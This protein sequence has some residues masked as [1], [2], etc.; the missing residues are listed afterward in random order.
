[1]KIISIIGARPQFI[2]HAAL[3]KKLDENFNHLSIHTG[4]HYD[5]E[6]SQ[7]FFDELKI[8]KPDFLFDSLKNQ[9]G[10]G[11]QTAN[12]LIDIEKVLLNEKPDYILVYG[13]TNSTIAGALAASKLGIKI[14]H[15][16][17]GLR[18]FNREMPEEINRLLTDQLSNILFVPNTEC[19]SNLN[20]EGINQG[21]YNVGDIMKDTISMIQSKLEKSEKEDYFLATIH[22]PYNTDSRDRILS[23]LKI[24]N[25]LDTKVIFPIHPRTNNLLSK[26]KINLDD[27]FNIKFIK[28]QGYKEFS[29]LVC[30]AK[31]VITDSG[32]VQKEAYFLKTP[33]ITLRSETE[34]RETLVGNWNQLIFENLEEIKTAIKVMPEKSKYDSSLYGTGKTAEQIVKTILNVHK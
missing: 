17:S 10:H 21:I 7:L 16:E 27:F 34:W 2:K 9:S 19:I 32:G 31:S 18:S 25:S 30:F 12:M 20:A 15:V 28:P 1:M 22:R 14:I 11:A 33:C 29:S 24:L 6:M 26:F 8:R 5:N 4:Q 23:I 13:D 3:S